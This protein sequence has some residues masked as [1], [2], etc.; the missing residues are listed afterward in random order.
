MPTT[1]NAPRVTNAK[2]GI[3]NIKLVTAQKANIMTARVLCEMIKSSLG[4]RGMDKMIL[5]KV[6]DIKITNDGATMLW[7]ADV[8]QPVAK[9]LVEV[10]RTTDREVGDGTTS[11]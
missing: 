11:A 4:P 9:M 1:V 8:G 10:S 5:N 3:R 6:G 7:E 2:K